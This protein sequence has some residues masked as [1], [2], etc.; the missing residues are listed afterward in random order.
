MRKFITFIFIVSIL[1]CACTE[2]NKTAA[3]WRKMEQALWNGQQYTDPAKA[4]EYLDQALKLEPN[5][6]ETLNKKGTAY[7]NMGQYQ[8]TVE[9]T[10]ESIRLM[11][12]YFWAYNNRGNA[13]AN[14]REFQKAIDDYNR[15]LQL[16]PDFTEAYNNRGTVYLLQ[17]NV[18]LGCRD[19]QKACTLGNCKMAQEAISKGYCR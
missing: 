5:N 19:V 10:T 6:P 13:Y 14:L 1:I 3:D 16:K 9:M 7:Y 8:R 2:S 15:V 4:I 17:G 12:N 18:E 11:P